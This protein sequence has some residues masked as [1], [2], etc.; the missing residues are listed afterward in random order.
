MDDLELDSRRIH[1]PSIP[2]TKASPGTKVPNVHSSQSHREERTR[3][4]PD[5]LGKTMIALLASIKTLEGGK[6]KVLF[7][8]PTRP[9]VLQH[10]E[11]F[12]MLLVEIKIEARRSEPFFTRQP[13]YSWQRRSG[14]P[15]TFWKTFSLLTGSFFLSWTRHIG[16]SVTIL[17][18]GFEMFKCPRTYDHDAWTPRM[19][20]RIAVKIGG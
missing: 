17:I 20:A 18:L 9:V 15:T 10:Y 8:T 14:S 4:P 13:T 12:Q 7:V 1:P 19:A 6:G 2:E 3:G 5:R 11:T 16:L